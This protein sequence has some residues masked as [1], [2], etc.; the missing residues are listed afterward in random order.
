MFNTLISKWRLKQATKQMKLEKLHIQELCDH[1]WEYAGKKL[2]ESYNGI[3]VDFDYYHI[4]V[5]K[6]CGKEIKNRIKD[7]IETTINI[8]KIKHLKDD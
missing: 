1:E 3:E 7:N 4:A 5:C 2:Y 6:H 8:S